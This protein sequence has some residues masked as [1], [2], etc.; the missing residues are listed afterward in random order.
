MAATKGVPPRRRRPPPLATGTIIPPEPSKSGA[1]EDEDPAVLDSPSS[2]P[3]SDND[4]PSGGGSDGG[5][6]SS[7]SGSDSDSSGGSSSG[8]DGDDGSDDSSDS[9]SDGDDDGGNRASSSAISAEEVRHAVALASEAAAETFGWKENKTDAIGRGGGRKKGHGNALSDIIPGYTAPLR[10]EASSA[11]SL[12]ATSGGGGGGGGRGS[13]GNSDLARLRR[14]AERS[15]ASSTVVGRGEARA[16]AS[17]LMGRVGDPKTASAMAVPSAF[18]TGPRRRPDR[19]AG[20]QWFGFNPER[21]TDE[22]RTD[23]ALIRNRSY[24]DPKKFYKKS[25][26][27]DGRMVQVGTVVEGTGE[28]FSSR[29]SKKE[30]KSNFAEEVMADGDVAGYTKRQYAKMQRAN[31]AK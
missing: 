31:E 7:S 6:D 15:D 3:E 27:I 1:G 19:T 10:L 17:A 16:R 29:L 30:R 11:S 26:K 22:L 14:N 20:D 28:Y 23:L 2:S 18:K 13:G 21:L 25:D 9:E 8:D 4:A 5:G 24:L 12:S